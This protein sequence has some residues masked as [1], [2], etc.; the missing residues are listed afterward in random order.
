MLY[1][2]ARACGVPQSVWDGHPIS[3]IKFD[4][5]ELEDGVDPPAVGGGAPTG[6]QWE[7]DD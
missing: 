5:V 1:A 7:S 4:R 2:S 6:A 3:D